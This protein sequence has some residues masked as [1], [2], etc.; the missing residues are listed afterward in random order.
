MDR[1]GGLHRVG[2]TGVVRQGD[3]VRMD[4]LADA[5]ELKLLELRAECG[6]GGIIGRIGDGQRHGGRMVELFVVAEQDGFLA[7]FDSARPGADL[8]E[9]LGRRRCL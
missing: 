8:D 4:R 9:S 1:R 7:E 6:K 3:H 2:R 5:R